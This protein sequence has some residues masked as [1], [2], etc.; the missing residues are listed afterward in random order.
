M[1]ARIR[2]FESKVFYYTYGPHPPAVTVRPGDT[3]RA[4][5]V[6]ARGMDENGDPI[7]ADRLHVEAGVEL[8]PFNPQTGPVY[9]EGAETGDT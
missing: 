5:T 3:V 4:Q 8:L 9:V 2:D 7:P 1:P 6:D